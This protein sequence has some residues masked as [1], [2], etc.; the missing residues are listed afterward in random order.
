MLSPFVRCGKCTAPMRG[1]V[2]GGGHVYW[3]RS[4]TDGGCGGC[5]RRGGEVD[6]Y[7]EL[8]IQDHER[9]SLRA[10]EQLP[11]WDKEDE[12]RIVRQKITEL[13]EQYRADNISGSTYFPLLAKLESDERKLKNERQRHEA[14]RTQR[15]EAIP[16]LRRQWADPNFALEQRQAAVA[17]SLIAVVIHPT[18]PGSRISTR[19]RSNPSGRSTLPNRNDA[20]GPSKAMI[21]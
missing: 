7:T 20:S 13:G 15:M 2:R 8:V 5:S 21:P 6:R 1:G 10:I 18:G 19:A 14:A 11:P 4:K 12:L 16:D 3:C 17:K 9:A